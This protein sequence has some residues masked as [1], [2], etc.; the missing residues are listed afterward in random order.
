MSFSDHS[1]NYQ[2]QLRTFYKTF[3]Y[4]EF[5]TAESVLFLLFSYHY[6]NEKNKIEMGM[7][8]EDFMGKDHVEEW[9]KNK[10]QY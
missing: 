4:E 10:V 1:H 6:N 2:A 8:L 3:G 9:V 5:N 7:W